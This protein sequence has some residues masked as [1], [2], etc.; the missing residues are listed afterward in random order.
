MRKVTTRG[1][2]F[3]HMVPVNSLCHNYDLRIPNY[4]VRNLIRSRFLLI[5]TMTTFAYPQA[6]KQVW[7]SEATVRSGKLRAKVSN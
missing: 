5:T 3:R 7:E 1:H 4:P 6:E 2:D